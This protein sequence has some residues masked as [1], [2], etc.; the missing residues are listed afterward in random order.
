MRIAPFTL[1]TISES[2]AV[3]EQV[4][5]PS[6]DRERAVESNHQGVVGEI[7]RTSLARILQAAL[8][9]QL[10]HQ[11]L[12]HMEPTDKGHQKDLYPEMI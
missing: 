4:L 7:L 1:R 5:V 10:K 3:Q 6:S 11:Q 2:P 9:A 8:L 12:L